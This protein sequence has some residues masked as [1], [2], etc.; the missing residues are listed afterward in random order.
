LIREG[1]VRD[2]RYQQI[3]DDLRTRIEH[4]EYTP[5]SQLPTEKKLREHYRASRNTVRDAVKVV[6]NLGL[7]QTQAGRGTFVA[8]KPEPLLI[9]IDGGLG[10][11][12]DTAQYLSDAR[13]RN[14]VT[15]APRVEVHEAWVAPELQL[16]ADDSVV[17]RHQERK[18][19]GTP[20]SLQTTFYPMQLVQKG[21]EKLL[22]ATNIEP[23]AVSY[24]SAT[25]HLTEVGWQNRVLVRAP[26][27]HETS[28]FRLAPDGRVAIIEIRRTA[29]EE[30]GAPLRLTVTTC[31]ADRNELQFNT[32]RV[33]GRA[34]PPGLAN[35]T[36][37][38]ASTNKPPS[39]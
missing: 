5:G 16:S 27:E 31:P 30:T 6:V 23:G 11:G 18:L 22:S 25:L 10:V 28:Y 35:G 38:I 17:S 9:T 19:G 7:V 20:W 33:P 2:P 14:P 26:D 3:A 37:P 21:A 32:G 8:E 4:G 24:L 1:I 12:G 34:S 39:G 15:S 13:G 36:T 29:F